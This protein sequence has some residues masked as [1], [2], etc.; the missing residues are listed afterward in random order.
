MKQVS[1]D[2]VTSGMVLAKNVYSKNE[3]LL[4]GKG[5]TLNNDHIMQLSR[6]GIQSFWV[7]TP[8]KKNEMSSEE[9]KKITK[10]VEEMLYAQFE[11]VSHNLIMNELKVVFAHY[12]I[13]KRTE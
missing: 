4:M 10:E 5:T 3:S 7:E 6:L 8:D 13:K 11:R 2:E 9:I 12:L 1:V